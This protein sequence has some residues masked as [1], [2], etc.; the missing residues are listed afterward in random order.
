MNQRTFLLESKFDKF[1]KKLY[2][3]GTCYTK[4]R[5]VTIN[6]TKILY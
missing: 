2:N 6:S 1:N 4:G 3:K 5:S